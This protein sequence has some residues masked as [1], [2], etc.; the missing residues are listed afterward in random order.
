MNDELSA[1]LLENGKFAECNSHFFIADE[2]TE[3]FKR[4]YAEFLREMFE[5]G[6]KITYGS[7]SHAKYAVPKH[8]A[9][10]E[11]VESY[12]RDVGFRDGDISELS[13]KYFW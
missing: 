8:M 13:E 4:Q 1:A 11:V 3:K 2:A 12:L 10:T 7:D 5:R 6:V 9:K